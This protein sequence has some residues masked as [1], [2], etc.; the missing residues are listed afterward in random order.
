MII[1]IIFILTLLIAVIYLLRTLFSG[2]HSNVCANC[3]G[4][5]YWKGIRGERNHCKVC[6]GSGKR[7]RASV[8]EK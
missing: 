3:E 5:G 4:E 7:R 6:D 1:R 8:V 2:A